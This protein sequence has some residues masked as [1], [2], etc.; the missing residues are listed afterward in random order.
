MGSTLGTVAGTVDPCPVSSGYHAQAYSEPMSQYTHIHNVVHRSS[1]FSSLFRALAI[2]NVLQCGR[3][4]GAA[5]LVKVHS[6]E[7]LSSEPVAVDAKSWQPQHSLLTYI[8]M[9]I[10][11]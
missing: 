8:M 4:W 9:C 2:H 11:P 1:T 5:W 10:M 7:A 3:F 6:R